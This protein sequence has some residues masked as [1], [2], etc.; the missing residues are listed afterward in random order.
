VGLFAAQSASIHEMT[1]PA[2]VVVSDDVAVPLLVLI[3]LFSAGLAASWQVVPSQR[4]TIIEWNWAE[5]PAMVET[6]TVVA[7]P[8]VV[9]APVHM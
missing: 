2:A 7:E 9:T 1:E 8:P 6:V 5:P 4:S 3:F